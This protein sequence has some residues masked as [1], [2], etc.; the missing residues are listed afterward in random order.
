MRLATWNFAFTIFVSPFFGGSAAAQQSASSKDAMILF[1]YW[2]K[3]GQEGAFF[4]G[5]RKHLEWHRRKQDPILWYAWNV[6]VGRHAGLFIDGAF[7]IAFA[8][9]DQR[10][11]PSGD[12]ADFE[13]T[14]AA[15]A[16]VNDRVLYRLRR[17]LS[18]ATPLE[19][20]RP[21]A[22]LEAFRY[23]LA[24]G[25]EKE[26]E[27][28][29]TKLEGASS[30]AFTVYEVVAGAHHAEFL[31]LSQHASWADVGGA[32]AGIEAITNLTSTAD[33][34]AA[35]AVLGS[36]VTSVESEIWLYRADL[37]YMP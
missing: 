5:Y 27:A 12:R 28:M 1:S 25:H 18:S 10:V 30:S 14:S 17:D 8:A 13:E 2:P 15:F 19:E 22:M 4:D 9:L 21:G 7:D 6:I 11:D 36:A 29:L 34:E 32:S 24:P 26:F 23:R 31:I 35:A 16:S 3:E 37:T 20:R 33:A